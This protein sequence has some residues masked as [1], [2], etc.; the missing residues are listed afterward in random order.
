MNDRTRMGSTFTR[1]P[2]RSRALMTLLT[3]KAPFAFRSVPYFL[4]TAV[5]HVL[6]FTGE[7]LLRLASCDSVF[8]YCCPLSHTVECIFACLTF[9]PLVSSLSSLHFVPQLP[10]E[11]T[12]EFA[13][14]TIAPKKN[15]SATLLNLAN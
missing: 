12:F 14:F 2:R 4:Q 11:A 9:V 13:E 7:S 5:E 3:L 6:V 15:T 1:C 10:L 8:S